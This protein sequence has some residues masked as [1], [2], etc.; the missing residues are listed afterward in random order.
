MALSSQTLLHRAGL[1]S[2]FRHRRCYVLRFLLTLALL[3]AV[4]AAQTEE[5]HFHN[6]PARQKRRTDRNR[7]PRNRKPSAKQTEASVGHVLLEE[8]HG[9]VAHDPADGFEAQPHREPSAGVRSL[10]Q[11]VAQS[12]AIAD[13][14]KVDWLEGKLE[15]G[16]AS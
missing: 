12:V 4:G 10:A 1:V 8:L 3:C 13:L 15:E 16:A 5:L 9:G 6:R 14:K 7:R 2:A 11:T